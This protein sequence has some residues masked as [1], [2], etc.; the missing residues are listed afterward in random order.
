MLAV[1]AG[2][3]VLLPCNCYGTDC[4]IERHRKQ[5][6]KQNNKKK[7]SGKYVDLLEEYKGN[8]WKE[9]LKRAKVWVQETFLLGHRLGFGVSRCEESR[10]VGSSSWFM[11]DSAEVN[12]QH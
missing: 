3:L 5:N 9:D 12:K 1:V 8:E 10:F 4:S 7:R 11:L 6:R 2:W